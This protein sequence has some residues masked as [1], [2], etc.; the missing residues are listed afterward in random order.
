MTKFTRSR[1][2]FWGDIRF[3]IGIA[4]VVVSIAGVW[5]VVS[6]SGRTTPVLQ[7][8]RTIVQGEALASSDFQVVEVGLGSL[9]GDYL[10][11][12]DL[13]SGQV[14]ARTVSEGELF[15]A[16]AAA[17]ADD[18]RSTT[19]VV[20]SSTGIPADV[21]AGTVVELWH[22]PPLDDGRAH[23]APR[24]LV[25][26]VTVAAVLESDGMLASDGTA[27]EIVIDRADVAD[28]LA[29]MTG[30]SALSVVPVGATS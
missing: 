5:L 14:A 22:A 20:E 19:I 6:S 2:A 25:A 29:A 13:Q 12:Q 9:T 26:D 23:D 7:A 10:A 17:D 27:V 24:I 11:P 16:T 3:L 21:A 28:V 8:N 1:R 30:G 4:L 15:P 18:S